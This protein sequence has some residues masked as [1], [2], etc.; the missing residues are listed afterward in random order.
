[1]YLN[2]INFNLRHLSLA[3]LFLAGLLSLHAS[4]KNQPLVNEEVRLNAAR[5]YL[6]DQPNQIA[7]FTKGL[8]CSSC[9]IGLR[10]HLSRIK[11]IDRKH[12]EKGVLL[13]AT[14]QL[15]VVALKAD[16]K[17]D[18]VAMTKAIHKAGYEVGLFYQWEEQAIRQTAAPE[19]N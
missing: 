4:G 14:K 10:I 5:E 16:A 18:L 6:T 15:I 8:V 3:A 19:I 11:S 12:F 13:D 1:M 9:G 7:I 2:K 17:P